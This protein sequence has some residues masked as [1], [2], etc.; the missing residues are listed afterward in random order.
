[1]LN[2][3]PIRSTAG[4]YSVYVATR[5]H[6]TLGD[7]NAHIIDEAGWNLIAD[8]TNQPYAPKILAQS[9]TSGAT[10]TN[11]KIGKDTGGTNNDFGG[12][13]GEILIFNRKFSSTEEAKVVDHLVH[14]WE[15][16]ST[17]T[18]SPSSISNLHSGWMHRTPQALPRISNQVSQWNDK[19]GNGRNV[20]QS[21]ANNIKPTLSSDSMTFNNSQYY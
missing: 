19:S 4:G 12:D 7:T 14:K 5:R 1:M 21:G 8:A 20:S 11:L 13:I 18:F 16:H 2:L 17:A 10:L 6:D 9:A 3:T 15:A